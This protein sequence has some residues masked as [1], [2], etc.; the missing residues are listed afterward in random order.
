MLNVYLSGEIHSNMIC[1]KK[2]LICEKV[3]IFG[4][5]RKIRFIKIFQLKSPVTNHEEKLRD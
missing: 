2:S 5:T 1:E 3:G 4:Q